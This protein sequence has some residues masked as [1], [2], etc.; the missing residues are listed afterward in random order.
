MRS[1]FS[2]AFIAFAGAL[3]FCLGT[4]PAIAQDAESMLKTAAQIDAG[5]TN[6]LATLYENDPITRVL[7]EKSVAVLIFPEIQ[8]IETMT[9]ERYGEGALRLGDVTAGYYSAARQPSIW[10]QNDSPADFRTYGYAMYFLNQ[11][12]L[13]YLINN[14]DWEVGVGPTIVGGGKGWCPCMGADN[15]S[16]DIAVVFFDQSGMVAGSG[17]KGSI[18][19]RIER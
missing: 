18:I 4:C 15:L 2:K 3:A 14:D 10:T 8:K 13:D 6:A 19:S 11:A 5:V 17:V 1:L 16:E 12:A 9:G 7:A